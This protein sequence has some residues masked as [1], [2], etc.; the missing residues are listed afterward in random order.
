MTNDFLI[1][2]LYFIPIADMTSFYMNGTFLFGIFQKSCG[3]LSH[4]CG[5]EGGGGFSSF[6]SGL[7]TSADEAWIYIQSLVK[8][9][10]FWLHWYKNCVFMSSISEDTVHSQISF[11][12]KANMFLHKNQ[13]FSCIF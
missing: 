11:V 4:F 8:K 6:V 10:N 2:S 1:I 3:G 9:T 5:V 13:L 7:V 12:Q